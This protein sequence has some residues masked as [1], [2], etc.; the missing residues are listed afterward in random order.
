MVDVLALDLS[1]T[2]T[3]IALPDGTLDTIR[4]PYLGDR[5][6]DDI[7]T[8]IEQAAINT[9]PDLSDLLVV[10][11]D[12]PTHARAAGITGMVHGAVRLTLIHWDISY[13]TVPP[14]TLKKYATGR[15]N[16]P[17]PDMRMALYKRTGQDVPD[18]NQVDAAWLRH[19]ALDLAGQPEIT[20][21]ANQRAVLNK[22]ALPTGA[23]A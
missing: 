20:L 13:F 5:R 10:I 4:P 18:D 9:T 21:P 23:P 11:E 2:A 8:R 1:I 22:L 7:A 16:A 14:A 3:G 19:L 17:K 15:G 6:L 12:L